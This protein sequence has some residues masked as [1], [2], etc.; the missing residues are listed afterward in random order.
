MFVPGRVLRDLQSITKYPH[1]LLTGS[2]APDNHVHKKRR[3]SEIAKKYNCQTLIETGTF[4]GQMVNFAKNRFDLVKSIELF[5]PLYELNRAAFS[6]NKNV[7]ILQG[8]STERLA[9]AISKSKGRILFWL[10]GHYSGDGTGCGDDI[11]PIITELKVI[12]EALRRD[13]CILIDDARLF[14]GTGGYP[15]Y[16]RTLAALRDINQEYQITKVGDC[17]SAM[18]KL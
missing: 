2:R 16:E 9:E 1:W 11:S 18:P 10:D 4:Y 15:S 5:E 12:S 14:T 7:E 13:N 17:I 3:I 8:N 6:R